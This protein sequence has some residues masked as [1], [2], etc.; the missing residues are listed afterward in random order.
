MVIKNSNQ[1][2]PPLQ[3]FNPI[4]WLFILFLNLHVTTIDNA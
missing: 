2:D 4:A 3:L 1:H